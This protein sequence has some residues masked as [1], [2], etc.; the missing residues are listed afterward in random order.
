MSDHADFYASLT[1]VEVESDQ[2]N[3]RKYE[4]KDTDGNVV[5]TRYE[6]IDPTQ[7]IAIPSRHENFMGK[8]ND[9]TVE[10]TEE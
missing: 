4:E 1:S 9:F 8:S 7:P 3:M 5:G 2:E 10:G 6:V